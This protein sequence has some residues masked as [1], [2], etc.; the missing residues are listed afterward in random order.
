MKNKIKAILLGSVFLFA[1]VMGL[2]INENKVSAGVGE[3]FYENFADSKL[4][5]SVATARGKQ[6]TDIIQPGD[7]TGLTNFS[8]Y[9]DV[10]IR[11]LSG[12]ETFTGLRVLMINN[13]PVEIVPDSIDQLVALQSLSIKYSELTAIPDAI[14]NMTSINY[15]ELSYNKLTS[16]PATIADMHNLSGLYIDGNPITALPV[17]SGSYPNLTELSASECGLITIDGINLSA[18]TNLRYLTL[19]YNELT[20]L[21]DDIGALTELNVLALYNNK[22]T[23]LPDSICQLTKVYDIGLYNNA[24][25]ALPSDFGNLN[26]INWLNLN[27]N[28]LTT[29]PDSFNQMSL[30]YTLTLDSNRITTLP[31][32]LSGLTSLGYL[33]LA[34]NNLSTLPEGISTTPNLNTLELSGN[35]IMDIPASFAGMTSLENVM[36]NRNGLT[37]FP[38]G[39]SNL[40]HLY[41]L[42][43]DDNDITEIPSDITS[44]NFPTLYDLSLSGNK[45]SGLPVFDSTVDFNLTLSRNQLTERLMP[46]ELNLR[47]S[48]QAVTLPS[49]SIEKADESDPVAID[50]LAELPPIITQYQEKMGGFFDATWIVEQ[51][52]TTEITIPG[53]DPDE[54][55]LINDALSAGFGDY[56]LK[57][58]INLAPP[59]RMFYNFLEGSVYE[60]PIT[61]SSDSALVGDTLLNGSVKDKATNL[62]IENATVELKEN[63]SLAGSRTTGTDGLYEFL[64]P[65]AKTYDIIASATGY[66]TVIGTVTVP[67]GE[68]VTKNFLL[69]AGEGTIIEKP[70]VPGGTVEGGGEEGSQLI[71]GILPKTGHAML[72]VLGSVILAMGALVLRRV[73]N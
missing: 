21:P 45:I 36:L 40:P 11:D 7:I 58:K 39:L 41:H 15:L 42:S 16:L 33:T 27:N 47:T 46:E 26:T 61:V 71:G 43:L 59:S 23:V 3:T 72:W 62:P 31:S 54:M 48:E 55:D 32:T 14:G 38:A 24:L 50:V 2:A 65:E 53:D 6:A 25:I 30:L 9:S 57:L 66:K 37:Q 12:I 60:L 44:A 8:L 52:D 4:A 68:T 10:G 64:D 51:P 63:N 19:S 34:D 20:T 70:E 35:Q 67:A 17:F 22:L 49:I 56:K 73:R 29:L 5:E 13:N 18:L 1:G 69:E 28:Q